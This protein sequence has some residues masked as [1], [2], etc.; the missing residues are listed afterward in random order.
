MTRPSPGRSR[1]V[2]SRYLGFGYSLVAAGVGLAA[3]LYAVGFLA[4]LGVPKTV[5][6]GATHAVGDPLV[7]N[8][9]LLAGFGLQHSLMARPAFKA[10]WTRVVPE[11]LERSTYVLFAGVALWLLLWGWRP[12]PATVWVVEGPAATLLLAVS[13][14]GWL[15]MFA[16]VAMIDMFALLGVRQGWAALQN[17]AFEPVGFQTPGFYRYVRHPIMTGFL[18]AFWATPEMSVGHLLFAAG[19][20]AYVLVGVLLE[21]RDLAVAFGERYEAYRERLPRFVPRPWRS[22][23]ASTEE[24]ALE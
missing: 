4:N 17:R 23:S 15:W 18:V 12:L 2:A 13:L 10:R 16:A 21:E 5:D 1:S 20:T 9:G 19:M 7:V 8:L 14:G 11:S 24:A 22:I 6:G 3:L